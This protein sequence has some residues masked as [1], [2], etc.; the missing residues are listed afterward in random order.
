MDG[1]LC[2]RVAI[3]GDR[4]RCDIESRTV[5]SLVFVVQRSVNSRALFRVCVCRLVVCAVDDVVRRST[6]RDIGAGYVA[7]KFCKIDNCFD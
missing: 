3:G 6:R 2:A 7:T 5:R 1:D 4:Y